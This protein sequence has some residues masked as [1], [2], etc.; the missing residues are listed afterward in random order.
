[1]IR[2]AAILS[3]LL[4]VGCT[5]RFHQLGMPLP[6]VQAEPVAGTTLQSVMARL[7]P[8]HR[9]TR[10]VSGWTLGWE[11]WRISESAFGAS[12]GVLGVDTLTFDWGD[13]RVRG[14]FLLVSFN[15]DHVATSVSRATWDNDIGGGASVQPFA[16]V[17][18]L[19]NVDDLLLPL[20]QHGW[21]G[22]AL[23][24]LPTAINNENRPGMG[25]NGLEQ[26]GTPRGI[27]QRTLEMQ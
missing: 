14:D 15:T 2:S 21:G 12:L 20:P 24:P 5:Q 7:G 11:H 17:A 19:V 8:P 18:P 4:L 13:A 25:S 16:G 10:S 26:R 6:S 9:L 1:M 22:A 3:V 23:M 27:G